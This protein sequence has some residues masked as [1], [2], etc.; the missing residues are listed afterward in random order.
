[1]EQWAMK[2]SILGPCNCDWGCP[3]N[4][5]VAPSYGHCEGIYAYA[6]D[7]GHYGD[8]RLDRLKYVHAGSWPAAVH[9]GNGTAV[10]I[11]DTG[12]SDDQR[13]ALEDLWK[14][15]EAGLPFDIW[16]AVTSTWLETIVAPIEM[17][18]AAMSSRVSVDGG[19]LL[20]L[21]MS[22]VKNPVT[23][24]DEIT[25]LDKPTGFTSKRTE[26]GTTEVFR[27]ECAGWSWDYSG[28]YGEFAEY[29]YS[30]PS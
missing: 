4:F 22:R 21:V 15:G 10:L 30:G 9:L 24:D 6:V 12:A 2:G 14:T 19:R 18:W 16:N 13:R 3:C 20:D 23:G 1:M 11:V 17:E 5:D 29:D 8:T 27:L 25:Y 26:L 7:E 28:K